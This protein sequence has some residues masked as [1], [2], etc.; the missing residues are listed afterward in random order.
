MGMS[1][2]DICNEYEYLDEYH[3][4]NPHREIWVCIE[5]VCKLIQTKIDK[6]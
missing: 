2:C 1:K 6:E 5:C 4:E 3:I